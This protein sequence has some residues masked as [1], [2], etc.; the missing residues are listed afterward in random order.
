MTKQALFSSILVLAWWVL[1][2]AQSIVDLGA[3]A[4]VAYLLLPAIAV[5]LYPRNALAFLVAVFFLPIGSVQIPRAFVFLFLTIF[6]VR[7]SRIPPKIKN[8]HNSFSGLLFGWLIICLVMV[9]IANDQ[10]LAIN[11]FLIQLQTVFF[12]LVMLMFL[13]SLDDIIFSIKWNCFFAG[14]AF[15]ICFYHWGWFESTWM[16]QKFISSSSAWS[17]VG[18]NTLSSIDDTQRFL[19]AGLDPNFFASMLIFP[20]FSAFGL[21]LSTRSKLKFAWW[22]I[23]I[24]CAF[25]ILG[26][27]SRSALLVTVICMVPLIFKF[28]KQAFIGVILLF[29]VFISMVTLVPAIQDRVLSIEV[30]LRESGGSFRA[31][32]ALAGLDLYLQSPLGVGLGSAEDIFRKYNTSGFENSHN[33]YIQVLLET[34]PLGLFFLIAILWLGLKRLNSFCNLHHCSND[35]N[36]VFIYRSIYFGMIGCIVFYATIPANDFKPLFIPSVL[37]F[38]LFRNYLKIKP[39]FSQLKII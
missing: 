13:E 35:M 28:T 19:W 26:T 1:I 10:D 20:F 39:Q 34:G 37:G 29:F 23:V 16:T 4:T 3:I 21:A 33:T 30:N 38:S 11:L 14:I 27:Y 6:F 22:A 5:W 9:F 18:K 17:T 2:A 12:C 8:I 24:L 25:G 31:E 7:I 15:F 36:M 32:R